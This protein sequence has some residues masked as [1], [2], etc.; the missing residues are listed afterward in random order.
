MSL[1]WFSIKRDNSGGY[2]WVLYSHNNHEVLRSQRVFNAPH[3]ARSAARR[4]YRIVSGADFNY[5]IGFKD[6][7]NRKVRA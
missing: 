7:K 2:I 4:L 6:K 1:S 3:H 5:G